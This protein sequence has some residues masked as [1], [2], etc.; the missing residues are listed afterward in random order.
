MS[1]S[2]TRSAKFRCSRIEN[3]AGSSS[4][5]TATV[6]TDKSDCQY[7]PSRCSKM[8]SPR[9]MWKYPLTCMTAS[10]DFRLWIEYH[11]VNVYCTE[12]VIYNRRILK[13]QRR[14][15]K[16][17]FWAEI[18]I[19]SCARVSYILKNWLLIIFPNILPF[20]GGFL[21]SVSHFYSVLLFLS[22]SLVFVFCVFVFSFSELLESLN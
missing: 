2:A 4:G 7:P 18:N 22:F 17:R 6:R 1:D 10:W 5:M 9:R 21:W 19:I 11:A 15:N 8:P 13:I 3:E 20:P 16:T 12:C 14:P